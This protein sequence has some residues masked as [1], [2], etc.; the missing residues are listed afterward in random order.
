[1]I[2]IV[3]AMAAS[4]YGQERKPAPIIK[5]KVLDSVKFSPVEGA[6]IR[7]RHAGTAVAT[8]RDGTF[9]LKIEVFPDTIEVRHLGYESKQYVVLHADELVVQLSPLENFLEEVAVNTGYQQ[10]PKERATGSFEFVDAKQLN[11]Q[12]GV[13]VIDRL[14]GQSTLLFDK[15]ASRPTIT[16]RGLST[17]QGNTDPLIILDNF[18][19]EGTVTDINPNDVESISLLKDAAAASIWGARASNGVIVITTKKGTMANKSQLHFTS[20]VQWRDKPDLF[21]YQQMT[22]RDVIDL[23]KLLFDA[24][25]YTASENSQRHPWLSPIVELLIQHRDQPEQLSDAALQRQLATYANIDSRDQYENYVYQ[26]GL[27]Q[28]Y[29]LSWSGGTE[30]STYYYSV[31]YDDNENNLQAKF[32]R[33]TFRANNSL[34]LT[35]SLRLQTQ[36]SY[37]HGNERSGREG[38]STNSS[39]FRPYLN[40][41]DEVGNEIPFYQLRTVYAQTAGNGLL[42]DWAKYPLSD[43]RYD[44][45]GTHSQQLLASVNL[46]YKFFDGLSAD[47]TYRYDQQSASQ[48]RIHGIESYYTRDLVNRY[49][50]INADETSA[51]YHMPQGGIYQGDETKLAAH[52][53]RTQLSFH[54]V[55]ATHAVDLLL[56]TEIRLMHNQSVTTGEYGYDEER[57]LFSLVDYVNPVKDLITG[58]STYIPYLNDHNSTKNN[59]ISQY[60]TGTYSFLSRY[61]LTASLRRDASNQF[62]LKTNDKWNPL[63]SVGLGWNLSDEAF[64]NLDALSTLKLRATIGE[65][66][67]L[68][69]S[70]TAVP[71]IL[72]QTNDNYTG[73][74][75][76]A[77]TNPVNPEL[78]WE[79]SRML[80]V[81]LDFITKGNRFS[82]SLE[83]YFK[84]G[85]DLFGL[86]PNDI[87]TGIAARITKNVANMEGSGFD[88]TLHAKW[89]DRN[90]KWNTDL[91]HSYNKSKVSDYYNPPSAA[92]LNTSNGEQINTLVGY[93]VYAIISFPWLGLNDEGNPI[94]VLNGAPSEE[95]QAI[96]RGDPKDL[97]YNGSATPTH[98]GSLNN[99]FYFHGFNLDI[100]LMYK[101]GYYFRRSS[102]FYATMVRNNKIG[103]GSAD[104]ANRWQ[105]SGDEAFTDVPAFFYPYDENME[106]LYQSSSALV[107]NGDHIRL[108]YINFG[109]RIDGMKLAGKQVQ[110][111]LY[112][113][114]ANVGMLWKA[115]DKG[116]D[117]DF[118]DTLPNPRTYALGLRAIF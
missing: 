3:L 37:V 35:S 82:G 90:L 22:S 99:S 98:Y 95:Y 42:L 86:A 18:P 84:K 43:S 102:V 48:Q 11:Q 14:E 77:I 53:I 16:L 23:E 47:V 91:R 49:T 36:L 88:V 4:A 97:I 74:P 9:F 33:L 15:N 79:R 8:Q 54:H 73:K 27:N 6:S 29:A 71:V 87:T 51:I 78:R 34:Q 31:G 38:Y 39:F 72:Y 106:T 116:L 109:Y 56:G 7:A 89:T 40:L 75:K 108:Q 62:G 113:N 115:N 69:P 30:K 66:G 80:N 111:Q 118:P 10:I 5:G 58:N 46:N 44:R 45:S 92:Y 107:E 103:H 28:Q 100:S 1:M 12:V 19:Y 112:L 85:N 13:N 114:V 70:M 32:N 81:G 55:W 2:L 25:Y 117:P 110:C 61:M 26:K 65:T 101:L 64:Y 105:K 83:A 50:E 17:I 20:S 52:N 67:N 24:G 93:P 63:W 68:D 104:F 76:A 94:S 41:L 59:F 60:F 21:Y 57:L 96:L